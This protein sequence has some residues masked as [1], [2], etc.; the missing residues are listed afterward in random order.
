MTMMK[1]HNKFRDL[2]TILTT[3]LI[4]LKDQKGLFNSLTFERSINPKT[5]KTNA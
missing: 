2:K 5:N 4:K 1:S 3:I